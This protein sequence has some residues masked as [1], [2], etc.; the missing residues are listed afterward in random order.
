MLDKIPL[1]IAQINNNQLTQGREGPPSVEE[2]QIESRGGEKADGTDANNGDKSD[3]RMPMPDQT[4][5]GQPLAAGGAT[6]DSTV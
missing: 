2:S 5:Y 3:D 6:D 1:E 4:V